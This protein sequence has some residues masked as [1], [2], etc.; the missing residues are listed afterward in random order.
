[1]SDLIN[2]KMELTYKAKACFVYLTN[3]FRFNKD[4][5]KNERQFDFLK[6]SLHYNEYIAVYEFVLFV[7]LSEKGFIIT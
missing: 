7:K 5:I 1:M 6:N 4:G 2:L 3:Y